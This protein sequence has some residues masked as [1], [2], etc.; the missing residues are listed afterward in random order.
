M[1]V[2]S[3]E[4]VHSYTGQRMSGS[5]SDRLVSNNFSGNA[6]HIH[7]SAFEIFKRQK[8]AKV[9]QFEHSEINQNPVSSW[10]FFRN[11]KPSRFLPTARIA[12][13]RISLAYD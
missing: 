10:K 11:Q 5:I 6:T 2:G 12:A 4:V 8:N 1:S 7:F 9:S 13:S 3:P